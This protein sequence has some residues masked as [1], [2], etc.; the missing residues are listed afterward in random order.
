MMRLLAESCGELLG[1]AGQRQPDEVGLRRWDGVAGLAQCRS[2]PGAFGDDGVGAGE[3]FVGR[4]EGG[5]RCRLRDARRAE[6]DV[7]LAERGDD[8][9]IAD[10]VADPQPRQPVGLRERAQHND[11]AV[12]ANQPEAV[13]Q[14]VVGDVLDIRL[15]ERDQDVAE[16]PTR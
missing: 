8:V 4:V 15:V 12:R 3:K 9:G 16:A 13:G 5:D 2:H 11:I 7:H 1:A 10:G 6:R 14:H